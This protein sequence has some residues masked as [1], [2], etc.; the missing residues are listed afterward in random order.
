MSNRG[1]W[2]ATNTFPLKFQA[3][4]V[5]GGGG[6]KKAPLFCILSKGGVVCAEER[7][8]VTKKSLSCVSSEGGVVSNGG[9]W[10]ATKPLCLMFEGGR[11][12]GFKWRVMVA[13]KG[14]PS[15]IQAM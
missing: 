13:K 4:E 1:W 11:C 3:T 15:C 12:G 5:E 2:W 6:Q 7:V 14:P 10:W 9:C 8:V